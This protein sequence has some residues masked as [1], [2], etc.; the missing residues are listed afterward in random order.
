MT[1]SK[2]AGKRAFPNLY[3]FLTGEGWSSGCQNP[4]THPY[5]QNWWTGQRWYW[6][7]RQEEQTETSIYI[8]DIHVKKQTRIHK[9]QTIGKIGE[10]GQIHASELN[11][12]VQTVQNSN[13][14]LDFRQYLAFPEPYYRKKKWDVILCA[15][16]L[17]RSHSTQPGFDPDHLPS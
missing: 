5:L 13:I 12:I 11:C 7:R 15:K 16:G 10:W 9:K 1:V 6:L 4:K 14:K 2:Q 3:C 17:N 8:K